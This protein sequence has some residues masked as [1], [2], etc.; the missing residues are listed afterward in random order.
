MKFYKPKAKKLIYLNSEKNCTITAFNSKN[1]SFEWNISDFQIDDLAEL[2]T[3]NFQYQGTIGT[4]IILFRIANLQ[5]QT[6]DYF[7]SDGNYPIILCTNPSS[8]KPDAY[9][10]D[11]S[12][13]L[14]PQIVNKISIM[15]T[16]DLTN[17]SSGINTL[18]KF[19]L[20]IAINEYQPEYEQITNTY[21]Q[22][23][24]T[25]GTQASTQI[26]SM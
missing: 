6:R 21:G 25:N 10:N 19:V 9:D 22:A 26:H 23:M 3:M 16:D 18:A 20:V 13:V 17:P 1:V 8:S 2:K 15:V 11:Y 5:I 4:N 24:N 12:L 7:S 14:I